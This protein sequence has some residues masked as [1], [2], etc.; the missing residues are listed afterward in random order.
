MFALFEFKCLSLV[1]K[2]RRLLIR[3]KRRKLTS[4]SVS[5]VAAHSIGRN[6]TSCIRNSRAFANS[7]P[8]VWVSASSSR[9]EENKFF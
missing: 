1:H 9:N 6:L 2:T 5:V 8:S 4:V 7:S 3:N